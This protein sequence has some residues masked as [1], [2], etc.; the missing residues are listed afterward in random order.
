M[1][2]EDRVFRL[3]SVTVAHGDKPLIRGASVHIAAG[4]AAALVG[5]A[6]RGPLRRF[7]GAEAS[8]HVTAPPVPVGAWDL[9]VSS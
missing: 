8:R 6:A 9:A 3:Q 5:P 2:R 7:H 1:S 4:E